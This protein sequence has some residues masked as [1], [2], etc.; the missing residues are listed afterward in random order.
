MLS[1]EL[2]VTTLNTPTHIWGDSINNIYLV[3]SGSQLIRTIN[4]TNNANL[5][6]VVAGNGAV[7]GYN[8]DNRTATTASLSYPYNVWLNP[9]GTL[10]LADLGNNRVRKVD[11]TSRIISTIAGKSGPGSYNGD[12]Q[13]ATNAALYSP[14]ALTG[15]R[16]ESSVFVADTINNRVRWISLGD[17]FIHTIAGIYLFFV[18]YSES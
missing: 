11:K 15:D 18:I 17:G 7:A 6:D 9:T 16:A 10:F 12:E 8:G 14:A 3:D 13:S 1:R 2:F 4:T 5:V